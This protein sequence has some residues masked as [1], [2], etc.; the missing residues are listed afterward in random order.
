MIKKVM[1]DKVIS[2][3]KTIYLCDICDEEIPK[4]DKVFIIASGKGSRILTESDPRLDFHE[5][6]FK[7]ITWKR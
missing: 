2:E 6:C 3:E 1:V 4:E 7:G 5:S